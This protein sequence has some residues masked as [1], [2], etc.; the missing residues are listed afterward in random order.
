MNLKAKEVPYSSVVGSSVSL[1]NDAGAVVALIMISVPNPQFDYK[2]TAAPIIEKITA[3]FCPSSPTES[4]EARLR[5]IL[6]VLNSVAPAAENLACNQEQADMDGCMVKV[7]R[8]ALD[9]VLAAV[10]TIQ[11]ATSGWPAVGG[12]APTYR[13]DYDGF[14]GTKIGAYRTREGREG[15]VLQ[16]ADTKIV[17]VYGANRVELVGDEAEKSEGGV[18]FVEGYFT[19]QYA[20]GERPPVGPSDP[21]ADTDVESRVRR[22][23][24]DGWGMSVDSFM[25]RFVEAGIGFVDTSEP[26]GCP[27]PTADRREI[28]DIRAREALD[29]VL[30]VDFKFGA[31]RK[32]AKQLARRAL[33]VLDGGAGA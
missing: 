26:R 30:T 18:K 11:A 2:S 5:A 6:A 24:Y 8:Q 25:Q 28:V 20:A 13:V 32:I 17:H 31:N 14:V 22:I 7:S 23:L 33:A 21:T 9:E 4:V 15:V 29:Y 27:Q 16:Q 10:V 1:V 19:D 12:K 3:T